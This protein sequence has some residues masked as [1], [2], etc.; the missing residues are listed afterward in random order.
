[1]QKFYEYLQEFPQ[2]KASFD[3]ASM[4]VFNDEQEQLEKASEKDWPR[5]LKESEE[6]R[7][8]E[9]AVEVII[10]AV[11]HYGHDHVAKAFFRAYVKNHRTLQADTM[12]SFFLFFKLY[13]GAAYDQRN[14]AAVATAKRFSEVVETEEI[15]LPRI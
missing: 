13:G 15:Y 6:M 10:N 8:V 11:N 2:I 1:M 9:D 12:R 3:E 5:L 4:A 7:K 14:R